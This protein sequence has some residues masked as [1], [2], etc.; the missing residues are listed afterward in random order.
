MRVS[1]SDSGPRSRCA[2][3]VFFFFAPSFPYRPFAHFNGAG[4]NG[5]TRACSQSVDVFGRK[6]I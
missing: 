6:Q 2:S 3:Y 1:V 4:M 5:V